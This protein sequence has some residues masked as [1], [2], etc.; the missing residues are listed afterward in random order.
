[1]VPTPQ[2]EDAAYWLTRAEEILSFLRKEQH[3][4]AVDAG[5]WFFKGNTVD[6]LASFLQRSVMSSAAPPDIPVE[7][8]Q[9]S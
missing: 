9:S 5:V 6:Q 2:S 7:I 4:G 1:M 3:I 8:T